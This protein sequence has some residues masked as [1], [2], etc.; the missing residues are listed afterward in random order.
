MDKENFRK[1]GDISFFRY[2][3]WAQLPYMGKPTKNE[4]CVMEL[5]MS[6]LSEKGMLV[7]R[8]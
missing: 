6:I 5:I 4:L 1:F 3:Y 8:G 2:L 7:F